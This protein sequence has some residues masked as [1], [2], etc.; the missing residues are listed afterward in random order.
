MWN[1]NKIDQAR[2]FW[3]VVKWN[4]DRKLPKDPDNPS[5]N[6]HKVKAILLL[7]QTSVATW[8]RN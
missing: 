3:A 8:H 6:V 5:I 2:A 7:F 1:S 4:S